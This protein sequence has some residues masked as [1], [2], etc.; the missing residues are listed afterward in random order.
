MALAGAIIV[1]RVLWL[2]WHSSHFSR[3]LDGNSNAGNVHWRLMPD[4]AFV[5]QGVNVLKI[6]SKRPNFCSR[7]LLRQ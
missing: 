7:L 5:P 4:L 1:R 2:A 6:H 3:V